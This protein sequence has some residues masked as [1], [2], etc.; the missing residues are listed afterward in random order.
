MRQQWSQLNK[1]QKGTFG[2]YVAKMEFA[3]YG[4]LVFTAEVDDRGIDFV[5]LLDADREGERQ[6]IRY[7]EMFGAAISRRVFTYADIDASWKAAS[8]EKIFSKDDR[9][10]IQSLFGDFD[11][12][13][14]KVFNRALQE[15]V[16]MKKNMDLDQ[17]TLSGFSKILAFIFEKLQVERSIAGW[18]K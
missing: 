8:F 5:V 14:K 4:F 15:Y 16:V 10:K 2:E 7:V 3:M 13:D 11:R 12:F 1:Q 17:E 6:K 18:S 9:L